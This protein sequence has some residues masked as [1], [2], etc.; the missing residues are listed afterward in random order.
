MVEQE[1][2]RRHGCGRGRFSGLF[3][4]GWPRVNRSSRRNRSGKQS[5]HHAGVAR[6]SD[7]LVMSEEQDCL[8]GGLWQESSKKLAYLYGWTDLFEEGELEETELR[9]VLLIGVMMGAAEANKLLAKRNR[10]TFLERLVAPRY[11]LTK[12]A[13]YPLIKI[14]L[15]RD[16]SKNRRVLWWVLSAGPER[17]ANPE[18][19]P[20]LE[21]SW[22]VLEKDTATV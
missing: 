18:M 16:Q 1:R 14:I 6:Y 10:Q 19:D 8:V 11:A 3:A 9:I 21:I 22:S 12:T 20:E 17:W 5:S 4:L 13:Y 2:G 15:K 7:F